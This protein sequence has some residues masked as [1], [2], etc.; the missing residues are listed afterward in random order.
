MRQGIVELDG[1][2]DSD[3]AAVPTS[4]CLT[5]PQDTTPAEPPAVAPTG[6]TAWSGARPGESDPDG[7][8][9]SAK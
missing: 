7:W 1:S 4:E 9:R 3:F 5:H 8:D 2:F 6:D